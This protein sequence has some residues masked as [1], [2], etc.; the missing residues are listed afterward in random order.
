MQTQKEKGKVYRQQ[1]CIRIYYIL[2]VKL[3]LEKKGLAA[4]VLDRFMNIYSGGIT[5]PMANNCFALNSQTR[6]L[7]YSKETCLVEYGS[8]MGLALFCRT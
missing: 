7:A 1:M 6:G 4:E 3:V 5:I 8:A 2:I